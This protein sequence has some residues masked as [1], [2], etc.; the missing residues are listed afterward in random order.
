MKLRPVIAGLV[1]LILA[2]VCL[3]CG[4]GGL[5]DDEMD[6][7]AAR[8]EQRLYPKLSGIVHQEFALLR[9]DLRRQ[10]ATPTASPSSSSQATKSPTAT[11]SPSL[12]SSPSSPPSP[13][14]ATTPTTDAVLVVEGITGLTLDDMES[15]I[16]HRVSILPQPGWET[17]T[18]RQVLDSILHVLLLAGRAHDEKVDTT[19]EFRQWVG[20]ALALDLLNLLY[21]DEEEGLPPLDAAAIDA[22]YEQIKELFRTPPYL[23]V[24]TIETATRPD[25][26]ALAARIRGGDDFAEVAK[27]SSLAPSASTGGAMGRIYPGSLDA[28]RYAL[29]DKLPLKQVS[30]PVDLGNGRWALYLVTDRH[31]EAVKPQDMVQAQVEASLREKR[32]AQIFRTLDEKAKAAVPNEL[33]LDLV[34]A[35]DDATVLAKVDTVTI[36]RKDFREALDA[37]EASQRSRFD[38]TEGRRQFLESLYRRALYYQYA[39]RDPGFRARHGAFMGYLGFEKLAQ[40]YV[41]RV[42]R[43][44]AEPTDAEVQAAYEAQKSSFKGPH[45]YLR[46]RHVFYGA[47]E[48]TPEAVEKARLA[49]EAG[50]AK[51]TSGTSLES[52]ARGESQD[53]L[54]AGN[55]G[56]TE[57]FSRGIGRYEDAYY[58][59]ARSLEPGQIVTAP[60]KTS[61]GWYL[62]QL[63]DLSETQ[64]FELVAAS[65]AA[66]LGQQKGRTLIQDTVKDEQGKRRVLQRLDVVDALDAG[67]RAEAAAAAGETVAVPSV[68]TTTATTAP[69]VKTLTFKAVRSPDGKLTLE[70]AA[71][72]NEPS[73]E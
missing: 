16:R 51:L 3:G 28:G 48:K 43:P 13:A 15:I 22:H 5:S 6:D 30:D 42:I 49:A 32:R 18:R 23:T 37:I 57:W 7:I 34:D 41:Q 12:S 46:T 35:T 25:A 14:D 39:Q 63:V 52:L 60:V 66:G 71:A 54:T 40:F 11:Q 9:D 56:L 26:S 62:I 58:D 20:N 72:G 64:P 2:M 50:L 38:T 36:T 53:R 17:Q 44:K 29:L 1:P 61:V 65:V 67:D 21:H 70:P 24:S 19:P 8:V 27:A 45:P 68:G 59:A 4:G 31:P 33:H 47:I 10:P 69:G 73:H 55:G